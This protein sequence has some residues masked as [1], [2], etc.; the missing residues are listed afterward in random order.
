MFIVVTEKELIGLSRG[1]EC[2]KDIHVIQSK[3]EGCDELRMNQPT[4]S[5]LLTATPELA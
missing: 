2:V 5:T 1:N 4:P 3:I